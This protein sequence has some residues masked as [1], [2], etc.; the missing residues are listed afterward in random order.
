MMKG[1][2]LVIVTMKYLGKI[3]ILGAEHIEGRF[4]II[5]SIGRS[6]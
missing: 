2:Q 1:K 4:L 3:K 6:K 5:T